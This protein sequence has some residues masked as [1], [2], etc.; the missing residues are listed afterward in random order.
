MALDI[1]VDNCAI[2]ECESEAGSGI[3]SGFASVSASECGCSF[4]A[5][6]FGKRCNSPQV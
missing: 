4:R 3:I 1:C 5:G 6:D 2:S